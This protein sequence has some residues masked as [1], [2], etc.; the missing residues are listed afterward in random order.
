MKIPM[1]KDMEEFKEDFYKGLIC[2]FNHGGHIS[3]GDSRIPKKIR[4]VHDG[5]LLPYMG[6]EETSPLFIR[7]PDRRW[8]GSY[9]QHPHGGRQ[10]KKKT[11]GKK[12]GKDLF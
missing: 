11:V 7:D 5:I 12:E 1:N 8:L 4:D 3:H 2:L 10:E 6:R 9:L